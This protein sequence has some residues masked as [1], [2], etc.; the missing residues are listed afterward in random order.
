MNAFLQ[1]F[2]I[3]SFFLNILSAGHFGCGAFF[4]FNIS[5]PKETE[6]MNELNRIFISQLYFD[7]FHIFMFMHLKRSK[8]IEKLKE[9]KTVDAI[10]FVRANDV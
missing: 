9:R 1:S 10:T 4:A 2:I 6:W 3:M 8:P 7:F 5:T